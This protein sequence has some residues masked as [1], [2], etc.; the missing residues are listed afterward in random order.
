MEVVDETGRQNRVENKVKTYHYKT[1]PVGAEEETPGG[2]SKTHCFNRHGRS[3]H[4]LPATV[5]GRCEKGMDCGVHKISDVFRVRREAEWGLLNGEW[6]LVKTCVFRKVVK[7]KV[8]WDQIKKPKCWLQD[9]C[10]FCQLGPLNGT[11]Q[12]SHQVYWIFK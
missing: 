1:M 7:W 5:T 10:L 12:S 3:S 11:T 8:K 9:M 4:L 6:G 2:S